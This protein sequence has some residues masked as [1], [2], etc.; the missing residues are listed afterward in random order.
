[1]VGDLTATTRRELFEIPQGVTYLNCANMS[2]QLRGVTEA[3]V[4]A[5]RG[6]AS[7][8]TLHAADWFA[9]TERLRTLFARLVNADMDGVAIVPSVSYGVALAAANG[10]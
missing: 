6:K 10:P 5:V 7:P 1:M 8:W 4:A 2:P 9:P 3:G